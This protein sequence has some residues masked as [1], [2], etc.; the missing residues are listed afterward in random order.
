[1][2]E[3]A[4][5]MEDLI[6]P[7]MSLSLPELFSPEHQLI[8]TL[9]EAVSSTELLRERA[10]ERFYRAV[11]AEEASEAAKKAQVERKTGELATT[12]ETK[13]DAESEDNRRS[14]IFTTT[15]VRHWNH[16]SEPANLADKEGS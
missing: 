1:M 8:E 9:R 7:P 6:P 5:D 11:A 4:E 3:E 2:P 12:V 14:I 13:A 10:M 16:T 15:S